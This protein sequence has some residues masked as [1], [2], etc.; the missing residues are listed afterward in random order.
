MPLASFS[1]DGKRLLLAHADHAARLWD[2]ASG[3]P[4]GAAMVHKATLHSAAFDAAGKRIVTASADGTARLW[5]AASGKSL[6]IV[7]RHDGEVRDAVFSRHGELLLSA[8]TDGLARLWRSGDGSPFGQ[9]MKHPAALL[10]A[11]FAPGDEQIVTLADDGV[12]RLWDPA[13]QSLLAEL[14]REGERPVLSLD[15]SGRL[16][17]TASAK[18]VARLWKAGGMGPLTDRVG[19]P[20][21][22]G[23]AVR[24]LSFNADGSLLATAAADGLVRLWST[25]TGKVG[26]ELKHR[27]EVLDVAFDAKGARLVSV[28]ADQNARVWDAGSGKLLGP[29]VLLADAAAPGTD[30]PLPVV[31]VGE[32]TLVTVGGIT[33]LFTP[34]TSAAEQ[35]LGLDERA[36]L[37]SMIDQ[38]KRDNATLQGQSLKLA[39]DL[40]A[41]RQPAAA[42]DDFASGVQ[43]ALDEL[44][45]RLVNMSNPVSNFAVRGLKLE[46]SVYV[47]VTPLGSIEYRF[48]QPGDKVEASSLSRL[49]LDLVP[50]PKSNLAGV[51]TPNLF[52]P[53]VGIAA[54]PGLL[55]PQ[56]D[57]LERAGL[58][59]IGEF[60]QVA[61]R[62]R[63]QATLEALLGADR[64]RIA[65]WAQ[66]AMLLALRGVDGGLA[67]L[68][69]AAGY[70]SLDA[71]AAST[72]AAL[73]S[74]LDAARDRPDAQPAAAVDEAL[75]E[76]WIRAARQFLGQVDS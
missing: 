41:L 9:P 19:E 32:Q 10:S 53:E 40:A 75:A 55:P 21:E 22:H 35:P 20:L 69:I 1:A 52:Q 28:S 42:P 68:L 16:L 3:K 2:A 24:A 65:A 64:Q 31:S 66:Q 26:A 44:Q 33:G 30:K 43:Q 58:F 70:G 25:E 18:G 51:W 72:P 4:I 48:V 34:I 45:Q 29:T 46:T 49:T 13:G 67:L 7:V 57:S 50:V 14:L 17:A 6:S 8:D 36:N 11:A 71:L 62:S 15:P 5:D 12:V 63:S 74:A 56:A 38:L 27:A 54:L 73:V 76:Q 59:S 61:T 60:L 23:S 39:A 47:Q 37:L